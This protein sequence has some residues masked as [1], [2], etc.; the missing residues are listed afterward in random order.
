M[1]SHFRVF[2]LFDYFCQIYH[3]SESNTLINKQIKTHVPLYRICFSY[4]GNA[5]LSVCVNS[6]FST[7][8]DDPK[9]SF[10]IEHRQV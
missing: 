5:Y 10:Q 3:E 6:K 9:E 1:T 4:H 2:V 7:T 8:D